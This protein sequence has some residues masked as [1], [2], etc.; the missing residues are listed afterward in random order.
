[1]AAWLPVLVR[2]P[3]WSLEAACVV[4]GRR[5]TWRADW[6]DPIGVPAEPLRRFDSRLEE[7]LFRDLSRVGPEWEVL[8]EADPVQVGRRILTPDFT[9]VRDGRRIPVEVVGFWTAEYL[10]AKLE[11]LRSLPP[12]AGWIV[13]VDEELG[14]RREQIPDGDFLAFRRRVDAR[15]LLAMALRRCHA[16]PLA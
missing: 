2:A 16:V 5:G 6:R 13:C 14:V 12:G 11:A 4:G 7:R 8:R 1:M 9:L 10:R 15:E 3:R